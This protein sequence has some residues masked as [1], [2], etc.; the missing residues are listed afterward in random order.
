MKI[1]QLRIGNYVY[2]GRSKK[3]KTVF[4]IKLF[5]VGIEGIS[6]EIKVWLHDDKYIYHSLESKSIKPIPL[7]EEWLLRFGFEAF[8]SN[9][10]KDL[11]FFCMIYDLKTNT[12]YINDG[13]GYEGANILKKIQYVHQLQNLYWCLCGEE[14]TTPAL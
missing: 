1:E 12:F 11:D 10:R 3:Q 13:D 9:F 6:N 2:N 4:G 5:D 7:T 14:L 8:R